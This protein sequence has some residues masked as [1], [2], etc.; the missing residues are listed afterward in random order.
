M[1]E[2][3]IMRL[4]TG[5]L[6]VGLIGALYIYKIT[7]NKL[8]EISQECKNLVIRNDDINAENI[9]LKERTDYQQEL[10]KKTD[11]AKD[12][13]EVKLKQAQ[14]EKQAAESKEKFIKANERLETKQEATSEISNENQEKIG[15][16][17]GNA[18]VQ[19]EYGENSLELVFKE[20]YFRFC[21]EVLC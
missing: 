14:I 9:R 13:Q 10:L 17:F 21:F 3:E 16:L 2:L 8:K 19:G 4:I 20:V 18:N 15:F 5:V 7:N 6:L 12:V 1:S 11:I